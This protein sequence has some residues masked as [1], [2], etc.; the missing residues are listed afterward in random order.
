MQGVAESVNNNLHV[1][2]IHA[3]ACL[4]GEQEQG[5]CHDWISGTATAWTMRRRIGSRTTGRRRER[6]CHRLV[7]GPK[8][9]ATEGRQQ[10]TRLRG[11]FRS[12]SWCPGE[13]SNLHGFTR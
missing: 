2:R 4:R 13:D 10:K 11:S 9:A 8:R 7:A 6:F 1:Q 5:R 12:E 3:A